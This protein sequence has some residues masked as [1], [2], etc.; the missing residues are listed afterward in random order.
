MGLDYY[1]SVPSAVETG[2]RIV[3]DAGQEFDWDP[4]PIARTRDCRRSAC[5]RIA[6]LRT[7]SSCDYAG[8]R[9]AV[10]NL[11]RWG[12]L[13]SSTSTVVRPIAV[14]PMIST[15]RYSK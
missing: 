12:A 6:G 5:R 9:E 14:L 10:R 1:L 11:T 4:F 7:T 2:M 13:S 3:S 8:S 15:P